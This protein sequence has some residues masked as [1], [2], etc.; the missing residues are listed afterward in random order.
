MS[1]SMENEDR[2]RNSIS[3]KDP[4]TRSMAEESKGAN[5]TN[6]E[7]AFHE[8]YANTRHIR[9]QTDRMVE[10][11]LE[12]QTAARRHAARTLL[13]QIEQLLR[14]QALLINLVEDIHRRLPQPLPADT[15]ANPLAEGFP[16]PPKAMKQP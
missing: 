13:G 6:V 7:E 16:P 5:E 8:M 9:T 14:N 1:E 2:D 10:H 3:G 4:A 12:G 15:G 11:V